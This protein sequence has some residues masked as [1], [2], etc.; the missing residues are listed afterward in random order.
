MRKIVGKPTCW[1]CTVGTVDSQVSSSSSDLVA[2]VKSPRPLLIE[3]ALMSYV[4]I[5]LGS[6][7]SGS[8]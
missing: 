2:F 3:A 7:L 6:C 5:L 4:W 8:E 1:P